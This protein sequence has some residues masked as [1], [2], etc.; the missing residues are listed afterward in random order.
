MKAQV[1]GSTH[2]YLYLNRDIDERIRLYQGPREAGLQ[3]E[4]GEDSDRKIIL[5]IDKK[6]NSSEIR[7][8]PEI[9]PKTTHVIL[10]F[11]DYNTLAMNDFFIMRDGG[12]SYQIEETDISNLL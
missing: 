12:D 8:E 10:S 1:C 6:I 5:L 3:G 7:H 11:Y 9:N 4:D 2:Y